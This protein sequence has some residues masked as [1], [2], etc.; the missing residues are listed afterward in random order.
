MEDL[1][2]VLVVDGCLLGDLVDECLDAGVGVGVL[3]FHDFDG[4]L[5]LVFDV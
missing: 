2:D 3:L 5:L 4:V 1:D